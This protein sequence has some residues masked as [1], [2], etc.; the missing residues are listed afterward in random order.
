V[1]KKELW[2]DLGFRDL[3]FQPLPDQLLLQTQAF[4]V[5]GYPLS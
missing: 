3:V 4:G 2:R 1:L 5:H